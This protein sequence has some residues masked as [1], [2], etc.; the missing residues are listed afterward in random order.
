[1]DFQASQPMVCVTVP[2]MLMYSIMSSAELHK[3]I[4]TAIPRIV[5]CLK[6]S[7]RNVRWAAFN[8]L[9]SLTT[10]GT[11]HCSSNADVFN[12]VFS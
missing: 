1:M 7:Q 2:P 4:Q 10:H 12:H 3:D 5:R 8:G 11:C 9:S 6:D